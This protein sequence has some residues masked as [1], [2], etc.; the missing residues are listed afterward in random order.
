MNSSLKSRPGAYQL[1]LSRRE[2]RIIVK[3]L[4]QLATA[5][6]GDNLPSVAFRCACV[7]VYTVLHVFTATATTCH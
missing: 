6:P 5:E 7:C 2:E 1:E 3:T 4:A